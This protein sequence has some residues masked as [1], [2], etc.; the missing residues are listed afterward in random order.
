[1]TVKSARD[2]SELNTGESP[3]LWRVSTCLQKMTPCFYLVNVGESLYKCKR[4]QLAV[5]ESTSVQS[6]DS[7]EPELP[8]I[9][10]GSVVQAPSSADSALVKS[11]LHPTQSKPHHQ[12]DTRKL[13]L[14]DCPSHPRGLICRDLTISS[15][16]WRWVQLADHSFNWNSNSSILLKHQLLPLFYWFA[17]IF[18]CN[19]MFPT[20]LNS[21]YGCTYANIFSARRILF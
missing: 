2:L 10:E 16:A 6:L 18:P 11:L 8:P 14:A 7:N 19:A 13:V 15:R 5:A 21:I 1:M 4:V 12:K 17:L 9:V 3:A 20:V